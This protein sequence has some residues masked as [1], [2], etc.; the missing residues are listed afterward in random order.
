MSSTDKVRGM[1]T[2]RRTF[3]KA[4]GAG[5]AAAGLGAALPT[6]FLGRGLAATKSLKIIQWSHFVPDYDKWIDAFAGAWGEKNGVDVKIDHIP[7]LELPARAAAEVTAQAGHDLF[8]FAGAGGPHLYMR[9]LEDLGPLVGEFEGRYGKVGLIGRQIAYDIESRTWPAFPD[10][11]ISFPG[12]YRK[13]L[14]GEI[15]MTPDTWEDL[16]VGGAKLKAKGFPVGI[17]LAHHVDANVSW[18]SVLWSFGAS[19]QDASGKRVAINSKEALEAVRFARALYKEAMTPEVMSWDDASNNLLLASGKGSYIHNPI[20]AYR[21]IQNANPELAD[22]IF[23]WKT[24][25]G[26]AQRLACGSPNS[27]GIWKFARNKETALEFL[28]H[29]AEHWAEGFKAS[30]GYNHPVF[31]DLVPKPMP[32]L[33]NDPSSHPP[34]KLTVLETVNDWHAVYGYP[35]PAGPAPDEVANAFIVPDMMAAAATDKMTP[36]DAVKW[37][38]NEI[39]QIYKKWIT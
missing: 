6:P 15:G 35:G 9:H 20:S 14:W 25:A 11:F 17:G 18:R 1:R 19:V 26:P 10:Y 22:K 8:H 21:T 23:V 31:A 2:A 16:R 32:I 24:P 5:L 4:T 29:Y 34:D 7:H 3:L 28:R 36:E 33:S 38:E 27:Y 12:L 39:R 30:T 37:A 13:D